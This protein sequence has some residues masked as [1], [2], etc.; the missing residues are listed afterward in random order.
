MVVSEGET[1]VEPLGATPL[2]SGSIAQDSASVEPHESVVLSSFITTSGA[3]VKLI[4]G[5]V[6]KRDSRVKQLYT[7]NPDLIV[8]GGSDKRKRIL[9]EYNFEDEQNDIKS[10]QKS[11]E[12]LK[13]EETYVPPMDYIEMKKTKE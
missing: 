1:V 10:T 7:F 3:A 11:L 9:I 8:K 6:L 2:I 5:N 13:K 4:E 12:Q